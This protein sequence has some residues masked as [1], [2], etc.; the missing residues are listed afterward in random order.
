MMMTVMPDLSLLENLLS[1]V[2]CEP[3]IHH[4]EYFH[5]TKQTVDG[6][7]GDVQQV[8]RM[9]EML[10]SQC[11]GTSRLDHLIKFCQERGIR[12]SDGSPVQEKDLLRL[13]L[14][15]R[16]NALESGIFLYAAML[17][18]ADQPNCVKFR[19]THDQTYSEVRT[20]RPVAP[21][22]PLTISYVPGILSHATRRRH[23]W[24]Q[25]RFDIGAELAPGLRRMELVG[26]QLP[27]SSLNRW[28]PDSTT[29]RIEKAVEE[30]RDMHREVADAA[31]T[32]HCADSE[33]VEQIEAMEQ[34][35]LELCSEAERQLEN[36]THLLLLPC[37]QLHLDGCDLV[38]RHASLLAGR[39][40]V[41][42]LGRLVASARKLVTL[43]RLF[44]G[45]DHF[46]LARTNLDL[47]QAIEELLSKSTRE[48][49]SLQLEGINTVSSW[50]ALE[51]TSRKEYN[52]IKVLYP[53]DVEEFIGEKA[54][55][56][57]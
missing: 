37:R 49:L 38:Q 11:M 41:K 19:P 9:M 17:N 27:S 45:P 8:V 40:R 57:E 16:Y 35:S 56:A 6:S 52:R 34:A 53:H 50:S 54:N 21:G 31:T 39:Q 51:N 48:L 20:T 22:E 32:S 33:F 13:C 2:D 5:P 25:H 24:E 47:A 42:L 26:G 28:N 14:T 36:D 18:H 23:L 1:G 30:L 12:N 3:F 46:D 4:M 43:Q 15:L 7:V 55:G 44:H 29:H 10:Q